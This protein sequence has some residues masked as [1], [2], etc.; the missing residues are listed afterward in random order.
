MRV[1]QL[2]LSNSNLKY[3]SQSYGRL[4]KLQDQIM[5]GKKIT[6]PS[7]DP[8]VAMK[9]MRYRSQVVEVDQFKRNLN[10]G[11]NWMDNADAALD[12]TT[13]VLH[14]IREL[15]VQASNDSY[16]A[17]ARKNISKEIER[18][19]EHIEALANSR[20]G[21]N[22]IFNGT[23]T[24]E[25]PI[26]ENQFNMDF[27][28]FL[29]NVATKAGDYVLSYKG[30]SYKFD[31]VQEINGVDYHIFKAPSGDNLI[32]D[33]SSGVIKHEY[34]EEQ[35]HMDGTPISIKETINT[36][37]LIVSNKNAVSTNTQDVRIEVMK[38]VTI[39]I[40][41]RAQDAFSIELFGSLE[42]IKKMLTNPDTKGS[43]ITKALDSI[44]GFLG[45][46]VSTRAE[47]GAQTNR[48][49]MVQSRLLQQKVVAVQTLSDNED[50]DF[51]QVI[52][53]LT[54]QESLH[55]AALAAGARIIQP[56][57]MDFLR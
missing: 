33:A 2:M 45:D 53:D 27:N 36:D 39:P 8:V 23:D 52:I 46:I 29:T 38:G 21:E 15:V 24:S 5:S 55:R 9:G 12:E 47:L 14:R 31:D 54:I 4:G 35:K 7:D 50:I 17:D 16:D 13:Q 28:T 37:D 51:E 26:K 11:F 56:T 49:E 34:E 3:I 1:T 25:A 19:Q 43:E 20:V 48:A 30:Q 57:L 32:L 6:K 41:I 10:E 22:Y 42:S 40:N 18:L 44:D